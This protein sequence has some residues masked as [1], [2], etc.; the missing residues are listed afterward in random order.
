MSLPVHA[1]TIEA[2]D[3]LLLPDTPNQLVEILLT[4][5]A[6][7]TESIIG[8]DLFLQIDDAMSGPIITN[9]NLI[10]P[11][12]LFDGVLLSFGPNPV[13]DD[14]PINRQWE[15]SVVV[16]ASFNGG[17]GVVVI[18]D[19]ATLLATVE[20]DTTGV[21]PGVYDFLLSVTIGPNTFI[22]DF[23]DDQGFPLD[24]VLIN[25]T[26]TIRQVVIP[27]PASIGLLGLSLLAM[28]RRRR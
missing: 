23:T 25:G 16:D 10:A 22:T 17:A 26:L 12:A 19:V 15:D 8:L 3:H 18:P 21:A 2:G 20:I 6:A 4:G 1:V 28:A 14:F 27:E 13:P 11:G 7:E 24:A 9:M 5:S